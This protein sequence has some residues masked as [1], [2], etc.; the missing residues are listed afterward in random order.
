MSGIIFGGMR[1]VQDDWRTPRRG[2]GSDSHGASFLTKWQG[3]ISF[4]SHYHHHGIPFIIQSPTLPLCLLN[5]INRSSAQALACL[6]SL[7][8][9]CKNLVALTL[10][11]SNPLSR[12][13]FLF[14]VHTY[15][16][17]DQIFQKRP[18]ELLGLKHHQIAATERLRDVGRQGQQKAGGVARPSYAS[19]S[20]ELFPSQRHLFLHRE[21]LFRENVQP[22]DL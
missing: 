15:I 14:I 20:G 12:L 1:R 21:L 2:R 19:T 13:F 11:H 3:A 18:A 22:Q 16:D 7:P 5:V 6:L 4:N 10:F 17:L 9:P 8:E